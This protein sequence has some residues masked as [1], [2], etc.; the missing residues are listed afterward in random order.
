MR[1]SRNT[2]D[3]LAMC[4]N[5]SCESVPGILT[6]SSLQMPIPP[7]KK[8]VN[9]SNTK[10][11]NQQKLISKLLL[12]PSPKRALNYVMF[13]LLHRSFLLRV[14]WFHV[15]QSVHPHQN[16][17]IN[18]YLLKINSRL[19]KQLNTVEPNTVHPHSS[20]LSVE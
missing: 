3:Y 12:L 11:F 5:S 19:F 7:V 1:S 14:P 16:P 6:N 20:Y 8:D 4:N 13:L 17:E 2:E 15:S 9:P 10:L 18:K